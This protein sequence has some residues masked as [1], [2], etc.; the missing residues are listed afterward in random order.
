MENFS[1]YRWYQCDII[2]KNGNRDFW[3]RFIATS[4]QEAEEKITEI[5]KK[6]LKEPS[7]FNTGSIKALIRRFI[8][9]RYI[10][11][12]DIFRVPEDILERYDFL[13]ADETDAFYQKAKG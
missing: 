4:D 6:A 11:D 8:A 1:K 2:R 9:K 10:A 5:I 13:K 3:C 12:F 7:F